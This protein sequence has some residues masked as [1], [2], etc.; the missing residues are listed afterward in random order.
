MFTFQEEIKNIRS[1]KQL[2]KRL[3]NPDFAEPH[4]CSFITRSF[5]LFIYNETNSINLFWLCGV[6]ILSKNPYCG[7]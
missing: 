7:K 2:R 3:S 4:W 6:F 5:L 1:T